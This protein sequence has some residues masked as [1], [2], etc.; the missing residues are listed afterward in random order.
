M[1]VWTRGVRLSGNDGGRMIPAGKGLRLT[2]ARARI[3]GARGGAAKNVAAS[4]WIEGEL[5]T[6]VQIA[7]RLGVTRKTA[8]RKLKLA[9]EGNGPVTWAAL[10][11]QRGPM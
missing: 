8:N 4:W 2:S 5:L 7:A 11:G 3:A 1:R 6:A 9:R 10:T